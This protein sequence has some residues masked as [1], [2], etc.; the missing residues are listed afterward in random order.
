MKGKLFATTLCITGLAIISLPV[1]HADASWA[2]QYLRNNGY[3]SITNSDKVQ[4][5]NSINIPSTNAHTYYSYDYYRQYFNSKPVASPTDVKTSQD[6]DAKENHVNEMNYNV[7]QDETYML[8]LINNDR[9]KMGLNKLTMDTDLARIARLKSE[10]M[11]A[12]NYFSHESPTYGSPFEMMKD[13]GISYKMA[14]ENIAKNS[15]IYNAHKALMGSE[16]HR[17]N[18]LNPDYN[19][20]GIGIAKGQNNTYIITEMFIKE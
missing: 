17:T 8:Q 20:I 19:K 9:E 10:D 2:T 1:N 13:N 16:G 3:G 7:S 4:T 18:I 11:V 6:E 5:S 14:A 12:N 15:S